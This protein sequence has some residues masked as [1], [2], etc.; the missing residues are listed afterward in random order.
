MKR[1][2]TNNVMVECVEYDCHT[3]YDHGMFCLKKCLTAKFKIQGEDYHFNLTYLTEEPAPPTIDEMYKKEFLKHI[4][5]GLA[6]VA[7]D[8]GYT[9]V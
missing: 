8:L 1:T 7:K 3:R 5:E 6:K 9:Q 4:E 2:A